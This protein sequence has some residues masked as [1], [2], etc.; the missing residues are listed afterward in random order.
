MQTYTVVL[1]VDDATPNT[2]IRAAT[3][4]DATSD[5]D[6]RITNPTE[7]SFV[8]SFPPEDQLLEF[9]F[10]L[11][12]DNITECDEGFIVRSLPANPAFTA[13]TPG[14]LFPSTLIII[15]GNDN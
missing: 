2:N 15:A 10:T 11:F 14:V 5:N 9:A 1:L 3:L 4:S 7:R 13:P 8:L 6:Y 12:P